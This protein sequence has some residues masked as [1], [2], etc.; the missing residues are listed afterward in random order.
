MKPSLQ[1]P[2]ASYLGIQ[3]LMVIIP[4]IKLSNSLAFSSCIYN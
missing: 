1:D 2:H 3:K 4:E